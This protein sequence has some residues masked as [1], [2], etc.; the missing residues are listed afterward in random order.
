M[1]MFGECY[2]DHFVKF[3]GSPCD[4]RSVFQQI[5]GLPSIQVLSFDGVFEGCRVFCSLGLSHY[6]PEI[7]NIAE[8]FIATDDAWD[9]IPELTANVLFFAVQQKM[10]VGRGVAISGLQSVIPEFVDQYQK[11]AFYLTT[12]FNVPRKIAQVDCDGIPGKIYNMFPI[13]AKEYEFFCREGAETFENVLERNKVDVLH[14]SRKSC[15]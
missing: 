11:E 12:P 14:I 4:D 10:S 13:S 3:F 9:M 7:Q 1:K 6:Y 5:E 8:V 2:Y 15:V